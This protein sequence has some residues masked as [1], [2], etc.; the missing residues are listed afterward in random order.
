MDTFYI[1]DGAPELNKSMM[2][3][4]E[5]DD[6]GDNVLRKDRESIHSA[7]FVKMNAL[8]RHIQKSDDDEKQ[9]K[10]KMLGMGIRG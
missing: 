8:V 4:C 1:D 3:L 7:N 9:K 2:G 5:E 6:Y 10:G